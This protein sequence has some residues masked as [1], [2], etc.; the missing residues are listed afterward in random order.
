MHILNFSHIFL[1]CENNIK[2]FREIA[3][4]TMLKNLW[5]YLSR[6]SFFIKVTSY[7]F[8]T[9]LKCFFVDIFQGFC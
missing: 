7:V 2:E 8:A 3:A 1:H 5:K 6:Y 4:L 9:L